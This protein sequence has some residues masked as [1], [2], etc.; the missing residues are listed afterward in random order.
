MGHFTL[1]FAIVVQCFWNVFIA[2][3][4]THTTTNYATEMLML[5]LV[6][7]GTIPQTMDLRLSNMTYIS[8]VCMYVTRKAHVYPRQQ[9]LICLATLFILS[10]DYSALIIAAIS[11]DVYRDAP[12]CHLLRLFTCIRL[13]FSSLALYTT[14]NDEQYIQTAF[15]VGMC[16]HVCY[17]HFQYSPPASPPKSPSDSQTRRERELQNDIYH[18]YQ[19]IHVT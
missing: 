12:N 18:S 4:Q 3:R 6:M 15:L 17:E 1:I 5:I 14:I 2:V 9:P 19:P 10:H 16:Y 13:W 8:L 11:Y 7:L